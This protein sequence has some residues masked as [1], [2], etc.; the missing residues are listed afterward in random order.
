MDEKRRR[1]GKGRMKKDSFMYFAITGLEKRP[2]H[3]HVHLI[4]K[5]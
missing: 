4:N 5:F 3:Q 2:D 1:R